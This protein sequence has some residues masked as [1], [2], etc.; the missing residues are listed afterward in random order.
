MPKLIR[1]VIINSLIGILIGWVFSGAMLYF[2]VGG[3]G[4]LFMRSTD[5]LV[6]LFLLGISSGVT[7]GF[8][9][10]TTAIL[11]MPTDKDGFDRL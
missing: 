10:L 5:K 7:F 9:Y 3:I 4:Q 1:F 8:A 11:L 6:I 2:D